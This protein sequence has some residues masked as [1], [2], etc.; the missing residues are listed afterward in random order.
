MTLKPPN[1]ACTRPPSADGKQWCFWLVLLAVCLSLVLAAGKASRWASKERKMLIASQ[2]RA[3]SKNR[4]VIEQLRACWERGEYT[5]F[6]CGGFVS[7]KSR[8][9][10]RPPDVPNRK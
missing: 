1:K 5:V 8:L 4:W 3:Y 6:V 7:L 2:S 9:T 10:M